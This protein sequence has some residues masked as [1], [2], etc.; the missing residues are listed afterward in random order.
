MAKKNIFDSQESLDELNASLSSSS[1]ASASKLAQTVAASTTVLQLAVNGVTVSLDESSG[2]QNA[3]NTS[4]PGE[5]GT[6]TDI[7]LTMLPTAFSDRLSA[8]WSGHTP[9]GAALSGYNGSNTGENI[10]SLQSGTSNI[11]ETAFTDAAGHALSGYDSGLKT[12]AGAEIFLWTDSVDPNI[13]LGRKGI[14]STDH[15]VANASGDIV[16][17]GYLQQ[18]GTPVSGAKMW[19]VQY[20]S[21]FNP[22]SA[23]P[24]EPVDLNNHLWVTANQVKNFSLQGVPSGQNLFLMVGDSQVAVVITGQHPANQSTGAKLS[25]G[26][27]VNTSQ[28]NGGAIGTSNQA[29]DP[30]AG[31]TAGEGMYFTFVTGADPNYT[32]PKL[33]ETTADVEAN[34]AFSGLYTQSSASFKVSQVTGS[35]MAT[36]KVSAFNTAFKTGVNYVDSLGT[37]TDVVD[38]V[39]GVEVYKLDNGSYVPVTD[40]NLKITNNQD[41]TFTVQGI[42]AN[43]TISYQTETPHSR[44]LVQNVGSSNAQYNGSFDIGGFGFDQSQ[45]VTHEIGSHVLFEDDAPSASAVAEATASASLDETGGLKTVTIAA[46]TITGLFNAPT[47]GQDGAGTTDYALSGTD[48]GATGIYITGNTNEV[49]LVKIS[50]TEFQGWTSGDTTN[51]TKAFTVSIDGSTGVVT[52]T[53][54]AAIDQPVAGNTA[55]AYNDAVSL[56]GTAA[57]S[58]VQKVTDGD[59]DWATATSAKPLDI[60]FHDDGPVFNS[61]I[62]LAGFNI[63]DP[64]IGF[65][66]ATPGA[67]E[68]GSLV[69]TGLTGTVDGHSISN[70]QFTLQSETSTQAYYT[71]SFNYLPGP[72][73]TNTETE[74]GFVK[75]NKT[76]GT[77]IFDINTPIVGETTYSTSTP[78][79]TYNYDQIGNK[80]PE[81]VVQKYDDHFFGV[82]TGQVAEPPSDISDLTAGGDLVFSAGEVFNSSAKG[83]MNVA[84]TTV[85][86][87][88]DTVQAGELVN[89]DFYA[90]NP[91]LG[92]QSPPQNSTAAIDSGAAKAYATKVDIMLDQFNVGHEDVVVLLKLYDASTDSSTTRLLIADS[93]DDYVRDSTTGNYVLSIGK[94]DYDS[95]HYK[96]SG[97]QVMS[98]TQ[99]VTGEGYSLSTHQ[100]VALTATGNDL[101]N[102]SD[103]DVFKIIKLDIT[104]EQKSTYDTD[105]KFEGKVFD[106]DL[107]WTT[108]SFNVHLEAENNILAAPGVAFVLNGTPNAEV[109][110]VAPGGSTL[111]LTKAEYVLGFYN[112]F[113]T[114]VD[115]LKLGVA[116]DDTAGTGN[117]VESVSPVAD[118]A[119]ALAA[120][121]NALAGLHSTSSQSQLYAFEH[122]ANNGYLFEDINSDGVADQVIV[123]VGIDQN[124]IKAS[125]IVA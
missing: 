115:V 93:I 14:W 41:G 57:I 77:Y 72:N 10:L 74:T 98:S 4:G 56:T 43:Y 124:A 64:M 101:A 30:P 105:L 116:G 99:S 87:D 108:F 58:V 5:D 111:D 16:I 125:D 104:N 103:N 94:D 110:M 63:P 100:A 37:P 51:G 83:Y 54:N 29:I 78:I 23:N 12:T 65:Y 25:S 32:A 68:W 69:L 121:D 11:V 50:N 66:R 31:K 92:A 112:N 46:G 34:I 17:A 45:T 22:D 120:A 19:T 75:F 42:K 95:A 79:Q 40:P 44:L 49:K 88:S 24:D 33:T 21:V 113:Q 38:K 96:I 67:D 18:T 7:S 60:A 86:V 26:D 84:T 28:T 13:V 102:T 71:W 52:V 117:Y 122:D 107:D 6:D 20:Q 53:Q 85:G 90:I 123:L 109:F 36:L 55:D 114:G 76:D 15:Y 47:Y 119:A 73:S 118:Y 59:G 80:S 89:Y 2:L 3:A 61:I 81:I 1:S 39:V 35:T 27:T 62:N 106:G 70:A 48:G 9:M 97:L 91:V 8:L 82:L